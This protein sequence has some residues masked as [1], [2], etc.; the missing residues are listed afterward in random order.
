[1]LNRKWMLNALALL[2]TG[3]LAGFLVGKGFGVGHEEDHGHEAEEDHAEEGPHGGRLLEDGNFAIELQIFEDGVPPEYHAWAY[4]DGDPVPLSAVDLAVTLDRLGGETDTIA[5]EPAE[6]YLRGTSVVREP[7]SFDVTVE[8]RYGGE[9][10]QWRYESHEG[11]TTIS[12]RA[13]EAAGIDT[14]TVGPAEIRDTVTLYGTVRPDEERVYAV[15]ARFGG[16][17]RNVHASVGDRVSKGDTLATVENNDSL[18]RYSVQAP[19]DG[20]ILAR[21]VNVGDRADGKLFTLA[22]LS[23]VWVDFAAFPRDRARLATGQ[24]VHVINADGHHAA[25]TSLAYVAPMG[26]PASQSVLARALLPNP[27]GRWTPGLLVT[28]EVTVA[29]RRVPLAVQ[30]DA[31][32][33]FRDFTVV[34]AKFGETYEVRMLELGARDEDYAQVL[35]GIDA[36]IEYVTENSYLIKADVLKSG[37]SHDH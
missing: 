1:M 31:L 16:V 15:T 32:Q 12:A 17:V 3:L 10:H 27:E 21:H 18:Q 20:V 8:A 11:R 28:G 30:T 9:T 29:T 36:G 6:N 19:A 2:V 34:F 37:A 13:A 26:S 25:D 24:T 14:D 35:G 4:E 22:D 5:F 23:E 33:S 7:H